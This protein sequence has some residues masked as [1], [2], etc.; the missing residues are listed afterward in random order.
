MKSY[1]WIDCLFVTLVLILLSLCPI[2]AVAQK[3]KD[4]KATYYSNKLLGRRMSNGEFY[5][6]DSMTCAHRTLPFGTRI[7]VTNPRNG[8][9]VVVR[10]AD[11]GPFVRG[12]VIDLSYA[13]ARELGFLTAG[14]AYMKLEI[15]PDDFS[16]P[17]YNEEEDIPLQLQPVEYGMVGVGYEF[18]PQW[19]N[20]DDQ[21]R[22]VPRKVKP[23]LTPRKAK[24]AQ[25]P[26]K[27]SDKPAKAAVKAVPTAPKQPASDSRKGMQKG[28]NKWTK[29]F[30]DLFGGSDGK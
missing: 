27:A 25:K 10:V 13:A 1:F 21:P 12:R 19:R 7:L 29:F 2:S 30:R 14:V 8:R 28:E 5:H 23:N 22:T 4:G 3:I 11:R 6:P 18:I 26:R 16:I 24:K 20:Q 9:Q 17:Y 15:A